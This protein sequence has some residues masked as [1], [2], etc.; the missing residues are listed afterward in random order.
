MSNV[1]NVSNEPTTLAFTARSS[2]DIDAAYL[3]TVMQAGG[4]AAHAYKHL[5]YELLR[6]QAGMQV[7]DVGCGS[8]IDLP[9]LRSLVGSAG[10][11]IGLERNAALVR[12]ARQNIA[13]AGATDGTIMV[14]CAD[15]EQMPIPTASLDRVRA[16][17]ALQHAQHPAR[18]LAEMW[19]VLRPGGMLTVVE[20]DWG[21]VGV[22]PGG[23]CGDDDAAISQVLAWTKRQLAHALIGR[24]LHGLLRQ[25]GGEHWG[26]IQVQTLVFQL[27]WETVNPILQI[28]ESAEALSREQPTLRS[29]LEM[30]LRR[31]EEASA[32]GTFWAGV[33]LMF[34]T[35]QKVSA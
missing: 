7:L 30:W 33:P 13:A 34:A 17:R 22:F 4:A 35:A 32:R 3:A 19:R 8:G 1:S 11:V 29:E 18:V 20:P 24:Q 15:A 9:N 2:A 31:V 21:M 27:D 12:Q 6:V 14:M 5:S 16:D 28:S 25:M 10:L 23:A 26:Q